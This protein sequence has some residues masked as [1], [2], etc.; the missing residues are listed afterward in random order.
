MPKCMKQNISINI[1]LS[2]C[3]CILGIVFSITW[4]S[5][6]YFILTGFILSGFL[7]H[8]YHIVKYREQKNY[9]S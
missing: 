5:L 2:I 1:L 8:S 7:I 9:F 3:I 6:Q 4:H